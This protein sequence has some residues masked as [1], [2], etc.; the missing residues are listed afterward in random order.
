[1]LA[2]QGDHG[3]YVCSR[4]LHEGVLVSTGQ[5]KVKPQRSSARGQA[6]ASSH[7]E[8]HTSHYER[9][10]ECFT[11]CSRF[12]LEPCDST[13]VNAGTAS[14][15]DCTAASGHG[16]NRA[17]IKHKSSSMGTPVASVHPFDWSLLLQV[18]FLVHLQLDAA[19]LDSCAGRLA[20]PGNTQR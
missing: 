19:A 8:R 1:V 17:L 2:L 16:H 12:W 9:H 3:L 14:S 20:R 15:S 13:S 7:Y 10:T 6:T 18:E 11:G 5:H 4:R